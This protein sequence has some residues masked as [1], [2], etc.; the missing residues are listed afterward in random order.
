MV[1]RE[2]LLICL[3]FTVFEGAAHPYKRNL[4]K[5]N[6]VKGVTGGNITNLAEV[7]EAFQK[8]KEAVTQN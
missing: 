1:H 4:L 7:R 5:F 3:G 6:G 8:A 2:W